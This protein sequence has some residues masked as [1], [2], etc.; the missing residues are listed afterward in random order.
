MI[1]AHQILFTTYWK[2]DFYFIEL[3]KHIACFL[4]SILMVLL[5]RRK[6]A[7]ERML[8]CCINEAANVQP[9]RN[10]VQNYSL[11]DVFQS[12]FYH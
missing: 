7:E 12:E 10:V 11:L 3:F 9:P 5:W 2:F 6:H 4:L 8:M 1:F